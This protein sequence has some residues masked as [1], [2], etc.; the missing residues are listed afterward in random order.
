MPQPR[1]RQ[2]S[3]VVARDDPPIRRAI[4]LMQ[5]RMQTQP[6]PDTTNGYDVGENFMPLSQ[7]DGDDYINIRGEGDGG[8]ARAIVAVGY[9]A[10]SGSVRACHDDHNNMSRSIGTK[11][12]SP[13][14]C[15]A[16]SRDSDGVGSCGGC[17]VSD[18]MTGRYN[19]SS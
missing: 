7:D 3:P 5:G 4:L 18:K 15:A 19:A 13:V 6:H 8:V 2:S 9:G 14:H 17:H 16:V 11:I 12:L 1:H 10:G